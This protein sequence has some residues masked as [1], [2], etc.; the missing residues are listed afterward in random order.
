MGGRRSASRL[1]RYVALPSPYAPVAHTQPLP[2]RRAMRRT[3]PKRARTRLLRRSTGPPF[4]ARTRRRARCV[5]GPHW[6]LLPPTHSPRS[7]TRST[8]PT[9]SAVGNAARLAAGAGMPTARG[10]RLRTRSRRRGRRGCRANSVLRRALRESA[11]RAARSAAASHCCMLWR[12][13]SS[14][15]LI[16]PGSTS[17]SHPQHHFACA[18]AKRDCGTHRGVCVAE[19]DASDAVL[20]R[21]SQGRAGRGEAFHAPPKAADGDGQLLWRAP[22]AP[23]P[24]GVGCGD[25]RKPVCALVYVPS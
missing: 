20:F 11:A 8:P 6:C 10:R 21:L 25:V 14:G 22:C 1:G 5:R 3:W 19:A 9:R 24:M 7:H 12:I 13:S 4:H 16:W 23:W 2:S 17:L 18:P 15:R